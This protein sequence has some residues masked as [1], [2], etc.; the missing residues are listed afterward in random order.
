MQRLIALSRA[1]VMLLFLLIFDMA[2]KPSWGDVSLWV[3]LA[4][5]A[6]L[7]GILVR[8]GLQAKLAA[9]SAEPVREPA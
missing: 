6:I 2:V 9:A 7:A 8:N 5:F 4:G 1:D 3:A